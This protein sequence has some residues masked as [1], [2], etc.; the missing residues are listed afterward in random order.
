MTFSIIG[1]DTGVGHVIG[2]LWAD[3]ESDAKAVA[4]QFFPDCGDSLLIRRTEG[5]EIPMQFD[6]GSPQIH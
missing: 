2:T 4:A 5:T 6:V 3:D 1:R